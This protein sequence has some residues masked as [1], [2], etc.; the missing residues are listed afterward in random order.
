[1]QARIER[2]GR[3]D[4]GAGGR[5]CRSTRRHRPNLSHGAATRFAGQPSDEARDL[6]ASIAG[7]LAL[8]E[9]SAALTV[10]RLPRRLR[11]AWRL[12]RHWRSALASGALDIEVRLNVRPSIVIGS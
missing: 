2:H 11:A 1:M 4:H 10:G 6:E 3:I 7:S 9:E 5:P 8:A 12:R